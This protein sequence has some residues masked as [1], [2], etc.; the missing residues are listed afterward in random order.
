M[1]LD[2]TLTYVSKQD[3]A[4]RE[5]LILDLQGPSEYDAAAGGEIILPSFFNFRTGGILIETAQGKAEDS[6]ASCKFDPANSSLKFFDVDGVEEADDADLSANTYR[7]T[8]F[9]R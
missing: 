2:G 1:A 5:Q 6:V 8:V 7:L 9:G 4:D 3:I